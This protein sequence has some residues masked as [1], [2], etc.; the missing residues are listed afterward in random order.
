M[1]AVLLVAKALADRTRLRLLATLRAGPRSAGGL[2]RELGVAPSTVS[3]HLDLLQRA[4]LLRIQREGRWARCSLADPS[5]NSPAAAALRWALAGMSA[6]RR[7][8]SEADRSER[9]SFDAGPLPSG[10]AGAPERESE[11]PPGWLGPA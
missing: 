2:S 8:G 3:R 5:G 11:S 7:G 10:T 1:E 4:A 6:P 9:L